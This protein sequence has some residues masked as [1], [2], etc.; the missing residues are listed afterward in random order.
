M[1]K[2]PAGIRTKP[3]GVAP[4]FAD[5]R[6]FDEVIALA[7]DADDVMGVGDPVDLGLVRYARAQGTD[8]ILLAMPYRTRLGKVYVGRTVQDVYVTAPCSVLAYRQEEP[9]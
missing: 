9:K 5:P 2:L 6:S 4:S 1:M 7:S 8:L 3:E